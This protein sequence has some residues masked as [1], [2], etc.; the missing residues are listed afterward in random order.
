MNQHIK[1]AS[2]LLYDMFRCLNCK[3]EFDSESKK[4][5]VVVWD[6]ICF[7]RWSTRKKKARKSLVSKFKKPKQLDI[8]EGDDDVDAKFPKI[9]SQSMIID[10]KHGSKCFCCIY[11]FIDTALD[12]VL[13]LSPIDDSM[14]T[15]NNEENLFEE[16]KISPQKLSLF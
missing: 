2:L 9:R 5:W 14:L 16:S 8:E 10:S 3:T 1:W 13:S 12:P 6:L 15:K 4:M 7:Y 11:D